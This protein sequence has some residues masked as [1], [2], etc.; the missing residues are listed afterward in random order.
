M[1]FS[2]KPFAALLAS[3][4]LITC[5]L[6][7]YGKDAPRSF[8]QLK[9]YH[10]KTTEQY[11]AL[12]T[13]LQK[14]YLPAMHRNGF[15]TVGVFSTTEKDTADKRIY[16]FVPLSSLDKLPIIDVLL[17]KDKAYAADA[18]AYTNALYNTP[19]YTRM[20]VI[21]LQAFT[22]MPQSAVPVLPAPKSERIYELRSYE[23]PTEAYHI[24]K[25]AMFN[26]GDEISIFNRLGFNAVF[27]SSV[28]AG[29]RMPNLMYL[30]VYA[31]NDEHQK[32]WNA[33]RDDPK[34]K[35]LSAKP[36]YK[37]NVSH[38]DSIFLQAAEYSDF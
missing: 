29:D 10:Y 15:K 34:W 19:P 8:Y 38:I 33:F 14:A 32:H 1:K 18:K 7:G 30:T 21:V 16:V 23:S 20:E 31:N 6:S 36:E 2:V 22:G 5:S 25:V 24:N 13:Y 35:E 3:V 12:N 17:A 9:V 28:I 37:N 27:Y 11:N 26:V 4:I